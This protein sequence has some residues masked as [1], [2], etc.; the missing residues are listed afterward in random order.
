MVGLG[1]GCAFATAYTACPG[2]VIDVRRPQSGEGLMV[3]NVV[4]PGHAPRG[5]TAAL[6]FD[7]PAGTTITGA[8]FDAKLTGDRGWEAGVH[9]AT[10]D[11]WLWC[12]PG[13]PGS[14]GRWIHEELRGLATQ[15]IQALLR[16]VATRCL[17]DARHGFVVLRKVSVH[18]D[19]PSPPRLDA[20][21]GSL[22]AAAPAWQ[23]GGQDVAFDAADNSGIR[24]GRIELDGRVVHEDARGCDFARPVPCS[25]AAVGAWF[26]TRTWADGEHVLRL[27]AQDAGGNWSSVD[28]LVRVDNTAPAEP[29]PAVEGGDGW[30]PSRVRTL[31][32]PLPDGQAAPLTRA[33]IK[34]CR[35]G[36]ACEESAPALGAAPAGSAATAPVA[37]FDGP[38]EYTVRVALEDAAGNVGPHAAPV[39]VAL[40]RH[41]S[42]R[43][44]TSPPP[45]P[46]ATAARSPSTLWVSGPCRGSADTACGSAG[47]RPS[48]RPA[49]RSTICPRAARRSR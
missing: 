1:A 17:R 44:R 14:S 4:G 11:R 39:S 34:A 31:A 21:R 30:S 36:G 13:C 28:R 27:S 2:G 15:R 37:A 26:D 32:L 9:D 3:R 33:R 46:G 16:C 10:H 47:A 8:D 35:V 49:S 43:R 40:R 38:G 6:R 41:A 45:T 48:S 22:A 7:A 20:L 25:G 42:R 5:T 29:A 19:D 18:L 23:R 12:G 24:L